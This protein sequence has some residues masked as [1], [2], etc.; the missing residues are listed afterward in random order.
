MGK[1]KKKQKKLH[2]KSAFL[3]TSFQLE[4]IKFQE[5]EKNLDKLIGQYKIFS[6]FYSLY[7]FKTGLIISL[8]DYYFKVEL[9][10]DISKALAKWSDRW[11]Y[12]L[13]YQL[14][15][16]VVLYRINDSINT[17]D[18]KKYLRQVE[19]AILYFLAV[20]ST[21]LTGLIGSFGGDEIIKFKITGRDDFQAFWDKYHSRDILPMLN[22]WRQ[23]QI[24]LNNLIGCSDLKNKHTKIYARLQKIKQDPQN[25][26]RYKRINK[27]V[28]DA[29]IAIDCPKN[30]MLITTDSSFDCL[31]PPLGKKYSKYVKG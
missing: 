16:H 15:L 11:G 2:N 24:P 23:N 31:C 10:G 13:K 29:I 27:G 17:K 21:R 7:E 3:D 25:S 26:E 18:M 1:K 19:T 22:F 20:F 9:C 30:H 4:R 8:I 14:L 5:F 12:D 6:S 28:G